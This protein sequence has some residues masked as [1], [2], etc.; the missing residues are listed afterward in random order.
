[1]LNGRLD[2]KEDK[3]LAYSENFYH[4]TNRSGFIVNESEVMEATKAVT[5]RS[6]ASPKFE[7]LFPSLR[8]DLPRMLLESGAELTNFIQTML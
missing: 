2:G 7:R 6:T 4:P 1:M 5:K 3:T 8:C